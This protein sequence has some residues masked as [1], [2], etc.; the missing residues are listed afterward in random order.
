MVRVAASLIGLLAQAE[1]R[2]SELLS[3][4]SPQDS[5]VQLLTRRIEDLW[6]QLRNDLDLGYD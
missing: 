5:D 3:R 1:D 4:R 2:R 6:L